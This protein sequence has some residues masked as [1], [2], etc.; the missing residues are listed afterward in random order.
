[1]MPSQATADPMYVYFYEIGS[2]SGIQ[3]AADLHNF[4]T[5]GNIFLGYGPESAWIEVDTF[6]LGPPCY[7]ILTDP[8]SGAISDMVLVTIGGGGTIWSMMIQFASY[9]ATITIPAGAILGGSHPENGTVQ[10]MFDTPLSWGGY[11]SDSIQIRVQSS[12]TNEVEPPPPPPPPPPPT[13]VPE[14]TTLALL[15]IGL[16][17]L[18]VVKV[19]R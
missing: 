1:M 13:P 12:E 10:D 7:A 15:G 6:Y 9:P 4:Y 11:W 14:P 18:L 19:K 16:V 17:G 8:L 2:G 5:V 3:I